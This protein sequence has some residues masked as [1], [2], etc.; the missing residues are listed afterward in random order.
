M[1]LDDKTLELLRT[2]DL[3]LTELNLQYEQIGD[4][5]T[6]N[7]AH[8]LLNNSTLS[9]LYL[10]Q[11]NI[12]DKG[13]E[14]LAQVLYSDKCALSSLDLRFNKITDNGAKALAK[15]L[16]DN[17]TLS[18]LV[19]WHNSISIE[20]AKAFEEVLR[21]NLSLYKIDLR[22][23]RLT[24]EAMELLVAA[25]VNNFTITSL[26]LGKLPKGKSK[27]GRQC[28]SLIRRNLRYLKA[29]QWTALEQFDAGRVLLRKALAADNR[30]ISLANLPF[31]VREHIVKMLDKN[32]LMTQEQQRLVLNCAGWKR[33]EKEKLLIPTIS[34]KYTFFK[35]TKCDRLMK[36]LSINC[37]SEMPPAKRARVESS[38]SSY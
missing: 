30:N 35:K 22:D 2:N 19:L 13:A 38:C 14:A 36:P 24:C 21:S 27:L 37:Q 29:L 10:L 7:L 28:D 25:L 20:G 3:S 1:P 9:V 5:G 11:N 18:S 4:E 23:N 26:A 34:D 15:A 16:C 31:E 33:A 6:S 8:V 17:N 32:R 12:G